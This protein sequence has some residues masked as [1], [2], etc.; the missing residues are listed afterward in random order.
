M[1]RPR[2]TGTEAYLN[3]QYQY[4]WCIHKEDKIL[5]K[6]SSRHEDIG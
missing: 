4:I 1:I 3:S 2:P 5:R 6:Q